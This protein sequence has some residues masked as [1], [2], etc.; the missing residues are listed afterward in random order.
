MFA[1]S[2]HNTHGSY[3]EVVAVATALVVTVISTG[4]SSRSVAGKESLPPQPAVVRVAIDEYEFEFD[5]EIRAGRVVFRA[6]NVGTEFHELVIAPLPEDM[7][8][9]DEQLRSDT[10]RV[11]SPQAH[12]LGIP[13]GGHGAFAVDLVPG[14][15]SLV[16]F[17]TGPD[18]VLHARK[19]ENAEFRVQ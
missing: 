14:R 9:L 11:V 1:R 18:G 6:H 13:P 15:Y 16:C 12:L 2:S 7:P 4:C 17:A 3:V 19:G 10:R 5:P 8:P